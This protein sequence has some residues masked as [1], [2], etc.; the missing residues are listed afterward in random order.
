MAER[1]GGASRVRVEASDLPWAS[2]SKDQRY[3]AERAVDLLRS[4]ADQPRA[5]SRP[6]GWYL[7]W[8]DGRRANSV[9]LLDGGRG[10][11]K[12]T[13]L[14]TLVHAWAAERRRREWAQHRGP[15]AT[16]QEVDPLRECVGVPVDARFLPLDVI[17]LQPVPEGTSLLL[18]LAGV[19]ARLIEQLEMRD[20]GAKLRAPEEWR[21]FAQVVAAGWEPNVSARKAT[22]DPEAY[23]V[24]LEEAERRGLDV[25]IRF[26][27]LVDALLQDLAEAE[28]ESKDVLFVVPV[29]DADMNVPRSIELITLLRT[30][31]HP[32]VA[33]VLTGHSDMFLLALRTHFLGEVRRPLRGLAT[34][35]SDVNALSEPYTPIQFAEELYNRVVPPHHRCRL[36]PLS[37]DDRF[38]HPR[39][40]DREAHAG[41]LPPDTIATLMQGLTLPPPASGTLA[42]YFE[43]HAVV[44]GALPGRLRPLEDLRLDL[45][46][47]VLSAVEVAHK[48]FRL[49]VVRSPLLPK[50]R[51][52]LL[53]VFPVPRPG[54]PLLAFTAALEME[55]SDQILARVDV[56]TASGIELL[57]PDDMPRMFL[58]LKQTPRFE[59]T[60]EPKAAILLMLDLIADGAG[61]VV[62]GS[63][64]V[65]RPPTF[66]LSRVRTPALAKPLEVAWPIP[67]WEAPVDFALLGK[68][69]ERS[70]RGSTVE[71][72]GV[73][74]T[75]IEAVLGVAD[76]RDAALRGTQRPEP[77]PQRLAELARD[78]T[79]GSAR[80]AAGRQW[81][82]D[83]LG[84]LTS[85]ESGLPKSVRQALENASSNASYVNELGK[86][87]PLF[88]RARF[89]HNRTE[90]LNLRLSSVFPQATALEIRTLTRQVANELDRAGGGM[91]SFDE[92]LGLL[93]VVQPVGSFLGTTNDRLSTYVQ[94]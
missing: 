46:Q 2:L 10:S 36:D 51:A 93:R 69:W 38:Q 31:W 79:T 77:W 60:E 58:D 13:I 37:H 71:P 56:E 64:F 84:L 8:V 20:F 12:T 82:R 55:W 90:Q 76:D 5:I 39:R 23:A 61:A 67:A 94:E 72:S 18:R 49:A 47:H 65:R 88:D 21:R 15:H 17:D 30:I 50:E 85:P 29:D 70:Q 34:S 48:I 35:D 83:I 1:N 44:R 3:A 59:I 91:M 14:L 24:E 19:F 80:R 52:E 66:V 45:S 22:L 27:V 11:G 41:Q 26:R 92:R 81:A 40:E 25:Q 86:S 6:A 53:R 57:R 62:G 4:Y 63:P 32:R 78:T 87:Q 33:F 89:D 73:A 43:W 7:P 9:V 42:S 74:Q 16:A 28:R 75:F 68:V 54:E